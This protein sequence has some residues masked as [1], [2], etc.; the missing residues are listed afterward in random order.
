[1]FSIDSLIGKIKSEQDR[2]AASL[3]GGNASNFEAYKFTTGEHSGLAKA[4]EII[5]Q[6]LNDD[7]IDL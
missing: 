6:M 4:L 2:I 1:M 5:D 7:D 3:A